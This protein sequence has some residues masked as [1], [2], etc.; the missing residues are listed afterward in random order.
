MPGL[1]GIFTEYEQCIT[2]IYK[3]NSRGARSVCHFP[4]F[5][6]NLTKLYK[7]KWQI[8]KLF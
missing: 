1:P 5:F 8:T 4:L 7:S 6:L 3:I 2:D